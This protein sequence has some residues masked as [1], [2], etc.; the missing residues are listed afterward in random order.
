MKVVV[1]R[2]RRE[3]EK[4]VAASPE[5]VKK[6]VG[7]G[8]AVTVE[9]G[10][11]ATAG[12]SDAAF[13]AAGATIAGDAAALAAALAEADLVAKVQR[14]TPQE[15][16]AIRP[17]AAVIALMSPHAD[18]AALAAAAERGLAVFGLEF[19][20]RITRAQTMDV[21]SSQANLAGYRAVI[22]AA[23]HY[24]KCFPMFMTAAGTVQAAK[25]F[26]LGA[27]VAGLQ[28]IATARRLGCQVSAT[29]VRKA[30]GEQVESLGAKYVFID[31]KDGEGGGGYAR[32]LT[33]EEQKAQ[34]ELV[35]GHI[36]SQDI[37]ITT[38]QIPGRAAPRL[39]TRAMI[40]TM[41]PG[42][43]IVDLAVESGGNVEGS[44][45]GEVVQVG[46][47]TIVGYANVPSRIAVDASAL[48]ARNVYNFVQPL[49]D[50]ESKAFKPNWDD[51]VV[52]GA[53]LAREGKIVHPSLAA[54]A[55]EPP[56]APPKADAL[57]A[58]AEPITAAPGAAA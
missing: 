44:V 4:R 28:A 10:A 55:P 37:V 47:V 36:K 35:A 48:F 56:T 32:A 49:V 11:G 26:V 6:F 29:D 21:L 22:D 2:E 25:C 52:K 45:A 58:A 41:K 34:A 18:P 50:K 31:L 57:A 39:V 19:V 7:L 24:A 53:L 15:S 20:P 12:V 13:A 1:P 23:Y 54:K 8:A 33:P 14:P 51:E 5:T 9:A 27:G 38:A 42:A 43:V 46:G 40:D 30:A 17:G 16:A 3:G